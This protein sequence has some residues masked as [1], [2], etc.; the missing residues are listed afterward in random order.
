MDGHIH[1]GIADAIHTALLVL[2]IFAGWRTLVL[3]LI[4]SDYGPLR[5]IGKGLAW[6]VN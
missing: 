4:S 2:L 5:K 1:S 6:I 3:L